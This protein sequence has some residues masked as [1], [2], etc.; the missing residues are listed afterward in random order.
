M[1]RSRDGS[2]I[3]RREFLK[4]GVLAGVG[5]SILPLAGAAG[6]SVE[7]APQ[8]RRYST[9]GRTGLKISDISF[10]SSRLS[11]G[12]EDLV[13]HAFDRGINYFD[14][15]D[16]Y[17]GGESETTIGNAL[18]GKRDKVF[19]TSKTMARA[20]DSRGSMMT[21]LETSLRRLQTD[22]VDVYFNHAVNDPAR[23]KNPEWYEFVSQARSQG[24][25]RFTGMSGHAGNL[26]ECLDYAIDSGHC[27]VILCAHNF[28]QDPRFFQRFTRNFD[29]IAIQPE[30]PRLMEK[31]K[32]HGVG[33]VVMK[34]LMGARLNDMR[35]Y[36]SGGATFSQAAF[37]WVLSN[38]NVDALIVTMTSR[39]LIDEYLGASG[40]RATA[41]QDLPLL[42]RYASLNGDSQ[43]RPACNECA[44]ACPY[45]V[46]IADVMRTR[47]YARDYGDIRLARSEYAMLSG[48]AA[49][50]LSCD[51][52]PC[53]GACPHGIA[54]EVLLAATHRMLV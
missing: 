6:A 45:G 27:D 17:S 20:D 4:R 13:R 11:A 31:A 29:M 14:S 28:G 5:V 34:T 32:R 22:H 18:K 8:V 21:A 46:P 43:C 42:N 50:C 52:K 51:A 15:A 19:L 12:D 48:N 36:E 33:V 54:T 2:I 35:P 3:G 16:T 30:L 41:A 25:I 24:K 23:L 44:D 39:A 49:A 26:A 53:A 9:L 40:A 37:R 38:P 10:G 47:M 1:K 7:A